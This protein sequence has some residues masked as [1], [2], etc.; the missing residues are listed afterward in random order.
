MKL[1]ILILLVHRIHNF[2]I[3]PSPKVPKVITSQNQHSYMSWKR[4]RIYQIIIQIRHII[5]QIRHIIK[6]RYIIKIRHILH[7]SY[8]HK[9][10]SYHANLALIVS[11]EAIFIL[12]ALF[13][14][15]FVLFMFYLECWLI[16]I[17]FCLNI[18][19]FRPLFNMKFQ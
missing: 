10:P 11:V 9:N 3:N 17:L 14:L 18:I 8:H 7:S 5:I 15:L 16:I 6:I 19:H 2:R 4:I 1:K 13:Y 12:L